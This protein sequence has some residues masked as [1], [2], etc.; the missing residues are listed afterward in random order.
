MIRRIVKAPP[1]NI[2]VKYGMTHICVSRYLVYIRE[3]L[4]LTLFGD[5]DLLKIGVILT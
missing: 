4:V 3:V 5:N 1:I 2:N